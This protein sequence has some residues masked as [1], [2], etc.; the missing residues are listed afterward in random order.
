[1]TLHAAV[2]ALA[3]AL[4][5]RL[6]FGTM[7][8]LIYPAG[9]DASHITIKEI[10]G[11]R[12]PLPNEGYLRYTVDPFTGRFGDEWTGWIDIRHPSLKGGT[13]VDF[14]FDRSDH[15]VK[16]RS[17]VL[18]YSGVAGAAPRA[19]QMAPE[20]RVTDSHFANKAYMLQAGLSVLETATCHV[21]SPAAGMPNAFTFPIT[22]NDAVNGDEFAAV[23][24]NNGPL[25]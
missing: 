6:V 18:T 19:S 11:L 12:T 10:F 8:L 5:V 17:T 7:L 9:V 1:M 16:V 21:V 23:E 15:F 14:P 24:S 22:S 13:N 2:S 25:P 20:D 4:I 3:P